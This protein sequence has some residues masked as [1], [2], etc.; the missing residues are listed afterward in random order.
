MRK[1]LFL[2]LA[3]LAFASCKTPK[4]ITYL[5]DIQKNIT[6]QPQ[7]PS[8][9]RIESGDKL[10]IYVHSRDEQMT[11]LFNISNVNGNNNNN[12]RLY[13]VDQNGQIDFPVL[14]LITVKGMTREEVARTIKYQLV[15]SN[16]CYDAVVTVEY[17]NLHYSVMGEVGSKGEVKI[18]KDCITLLEALAKAGDLGIHG[19]RKNVMV[20]RE[21]GGTQTPYVVDLTQTE[22]VYSSPA[23]YIKQNDVIYVEPDNIQ[24]R[25]TKANGSS[26]YTP[27]FWISIV[28]FVSSMVLL[29]VKLK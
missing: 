17:G 22:S 13:S 7:A 28:S 26:S 14:G 12:I 1:I 23:Y 24:K 27:S 19:K 29:F 8:L 25:S 9:I 6:I 3:V 20:L 15:S 11:R 2:L 16:L 21:E 5:Q 18:E 10:N 4:D